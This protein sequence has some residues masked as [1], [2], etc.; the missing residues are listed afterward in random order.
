MTKS[1]YQTLEISESSTAEEI[2]ISYRRLAKIHHPDKGGSEDIFKEINNSYSILSDITKKQAYDSILHGRNTGNPFFNNG[3]N[4]FNQNFRATETS[5]FIS[6][7]DAYKGITRQVDM[8]GK[9][10]DVIIPPGFQTNQK[11]MMAG[12]GRGGSDL[13][14]TIIVRNDDNIKVVNILDLEI[15]I[16]IDIFE[17]MGGT[18]KKIELWDVHIGYVKINSETIPDI[19]K[20]IRIKGKGLKNQ[21]YNVTGDLYIKLN[22]TV[23]LAID[24]PDYLKESIEHYISDKYNITGDSDGHKNT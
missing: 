5:V 16:N 7:E 13:Y 15:I 17:Y 6:L 22:T 4:N 1:H 21:K 9:L 12:Q 18:K 20:S 11:I 3:F 23:P 8:G 14:V 19:S 2:K 24:I 10:I